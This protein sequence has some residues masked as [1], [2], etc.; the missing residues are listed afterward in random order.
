MRR[1]LLVLLFAVAL[2]PAIP[3]RCTEIGNAAAL[4]TEEEIRQHIRDWDTAL[5]L[6]DP[7]AL[8]RLLADDFTMT[9]ASGTVLTRTAY[10]TSIVKTPDFRGI[11]SLASENVTIIVQGNTATVTGRSPLKGRPRGRAQVLRGS[12]EF[13]DRWIK[14]DDEWRALSTT[15]VYPIR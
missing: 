5:R 8:G 14:V 11:A 15:A 7:N 12:Y 4:S 3:A 10:L 13:T 1:H 2:V 6:R 9:D